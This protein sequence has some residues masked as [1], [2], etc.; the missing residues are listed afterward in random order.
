M[1]VGV[2]CS[3]CIG[4]F[5]SE[6]TEDG[7]FGCGYDKTPF[8]NVLEDTCFL[9]GVVF[10]KVKQ[11]GFPKNGVFVVVGEIGAT[12]IQKIGGTPIQKQTRERV[13]TGVWH[14]TGCW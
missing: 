3:G 14:E 8:D 2:V 12:P 13:E 4:G 10:W 5:T 7:F 11:G 1:V 9:G 6:G